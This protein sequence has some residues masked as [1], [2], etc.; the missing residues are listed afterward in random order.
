M[1][2]KAKILVVTDVER[3][4][5]EFISRTLKCLPIAHVD[6][7]RAD[8]LGFAGL[9]QEVQVCFPL[10]VTWLPVFTWGMTVKFR[11]KLCLHLTYRL[12]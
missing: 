12:F 9:V 6:H 8:K 2:A 5:I 1:Q 7:M 11:A 10:I 3:D 4:D